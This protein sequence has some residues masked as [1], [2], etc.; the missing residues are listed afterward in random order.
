MMIQELNE[1][2][3]EIFRHLVETFVA[4]GAPVGSRALAKKLEFRLSPASVR[5]VMQDLEEA[6]LL[7]A[8]HTSA[9]RLPTQ[10]GLRLFVDGLMELGNLTA[11]E[12]AAIEGHCAA[13]GRSTQDVLTEATAMLSGL[14]GCA[15]L[16]VAPKNEAPLRLVEFVALGPGRALVVIVT[17]GGMVEN[18][19]IDIPLD[20]NPA[21][22]TE[23]GNFLSARLKGR[24]M[25]EARDEIRAE[26]NDRRQEFDQ[27]TSRVVEAGLAVWSGDDGRSTLIVRGRANLLDDVSAVAD[28]ERIRQL[29]DELETREAMLNLV[30]VTQGAE[31]VRIFIGSENKFFTLAGCAMIVAPLQNSRQKILGAIGVIGPTRLNYARV[32]PMVDFTAQMIGRLIG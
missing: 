24:G 4:T 20:M 2:S 23:A 8:P 28:L 17:E 25:A 19:V 14:S 7:Y 15:G 21:A 32:V 13:G 3:R 6:G 31:G 26:L 11:E 5:N 9:G 18:R 12:R 29:F 27:L 1:R 10:A 22:L 16:V 30:D